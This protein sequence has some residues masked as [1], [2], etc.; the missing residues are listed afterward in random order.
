[1]QTVYDFNL[2]NRQHKSWLIRIVTMLAGVLLL[3]TLAYG[4][5]YQVYG[6]YK[7][8]KQQEKNTVLVNAEPAR[9]NYQ[10]QRVI[11]AHLFG[12]K[13]AVVQK[14]QEKAPETKLDLTIEGLVHFVGS[15]NK[16]RAIISVKKKKGE[17]YQVGDELKNTQVKL[18]E[19][20]QDGVLLNR[21]GVIEN[22]AFIKKTVSG[23]RSVTNFE[24]VNST[25]PT[26]E[27]QIDEVM[28]K[29]QQSINNG[30][31]QQPRRA[32][33]KPNFRGLDEALEKM[34]KL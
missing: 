21:N 25:L 3:W 32:I 12:E 34:Q 16:A 17:L 26:R 2:S 20:R 29:R 33:R 19:I 14:L 24:P 8:R 22:L 10:I 18:E 15:Q 30:G 23:N 5:Y 4:L 9:S 11:A 27:Q 13:K 6:V 28:Q 1:M 31:A 7:E